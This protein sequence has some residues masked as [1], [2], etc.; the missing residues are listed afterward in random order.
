MEVTA[1]PT[2]AAAANRSELSPNLPA[3]AARRLASSLSSLT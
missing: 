3:Q 1:M 2:H